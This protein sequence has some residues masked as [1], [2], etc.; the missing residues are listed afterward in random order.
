[1]GAGAASGTRLAGYLIDMNHVDEFIAPTDNRLR[2]RFGELDITYDQRI[3]TPRPWTLAQSHWASELLEDS[4]AGTV[5]ELCAGARVTSVCTRSTELPGS[6][7]SSTATKP[8]A[9]TR[10][11]T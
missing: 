5:L 11:T 1:M 4:P 3:L 9:P 10:S 6:W 2:L 8:P 7:C